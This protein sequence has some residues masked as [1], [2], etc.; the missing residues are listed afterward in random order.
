MMLTR[1]MA[2]RMMMLTSE[3]SIIWKWM[4]INMYNVYILCVFINL[5]VYFIYRSLELTRCNGNLN[6]LVAAASQP[7]KPR[8]PRNE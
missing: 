2:E 8:D 6:T 3:T 5:F 7:K 4:N 1:S